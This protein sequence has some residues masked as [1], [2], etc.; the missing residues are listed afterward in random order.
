M[1]FD[2]LEHFLHQEM[3]VPP[4]S[5]LTYLPDGRR[6]TNG[7]LRELADASTLFVFDKSYLERAVNDGVAELRQPPVDADAAEAGL[8]AAHVHAE[9]VA[10]MLAAVR[11]QAAAL[12][13][14]GTALDLPPPRDRRL[15]A[16]SMRPAR[17]YMSALVRGEADALDGL[18]CVPAST[19]LLVLT[20]MRLRRS[21]CTVYP[22]RALRPYMSALKRGKPTR[23]AP[24]E[25]ARPIR[26]NAMQHPPHAARA[27]RPANARRVVR[28]RLAVCSR[29]R[30]PTCAYAL[31]MC[32]A[33]RPPSAG[34]AR[35]IFSFPRTTTCACPCSRASEPTSA[36]KPCVASVRISQLECAG[37]GM[38][39]VRD[40]ALAFAPLYGE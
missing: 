29:P 17:P 32:R 35:H 16:L 4:A 10:S 5:A 15:L 36:A 30:T 23:R 12:R 22:T 25:G 20:S 9:A 3:G 39:S 11:A 21:R 19:H 33:R 14:A 2:A 24:G 31:S 8:H 1:P 18:R 7:M 28:A 37:A 38:E 13:V 34:E 6:L 26:G 27:G 40:I